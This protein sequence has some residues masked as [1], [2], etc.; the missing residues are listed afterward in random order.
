MPRK[1]RKEVI[2]HMS[3]GTKLVITFIDSNA[4][5]RNFSF[6]YASPTATSNAIKTAAQAI[7]T[8]GSIFT[9]VPVSAKAAKLVTTT[10]TNININ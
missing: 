4:H 5:E 7:I 1:T 9:Y 8:N 2:N 10:E 3:I 6:A